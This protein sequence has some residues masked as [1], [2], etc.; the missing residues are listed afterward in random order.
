MN[1]LLRQRVIEGNKSTGMNGDRS[2]LSLSRMLRIATYNIVPLS[3]ASGV[4]EWVNYT[5][6]FGEFLTDTKKSIGAH[7][8]Y[9]P[10][11]WSGIVCRNLLHDVAGQK[12]MKKRKVFDTICSN[13]S[14]VFR[15]FFLEKF[16]HNIPAWH[17]KY[18]YFINLFI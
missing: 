3:P 12:K 2:S 6:P 10:G 7:S 11:E 18:F 9:Y 14:P 17:C 13:F 8:R 16:A 1:K 5:A 4:L 15:Y